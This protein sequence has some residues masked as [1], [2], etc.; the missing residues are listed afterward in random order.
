MTSTY[1][2]ASELL[3]A[4][5]DKVKTNIRAPIDVD[6]IAKF[7]RIEVNYDPS[8]ESMDA[9]GQICFDDGSP[10]IKLNPMQNKY[11]SRRRFTLA[12]ELG[13]FC[14]HRE[15]NTSGFI[16]SQKTMSRT[17]SYWDQYESEANNFAAQLLM[18]KDLIIEEGRL[19]IQEYSDDSISAK[20]FIE[21][22]SEKFQVSNKA[23][24]YRLKNI[25]ILK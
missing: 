13:H 9:I 2:N 25:G 4:F 22:I 16:D 14:L 21:K 24:E 6:S 17:A 18:P 3:K 5:S 10:V 20:L 11:E 19:I 15:A 8:L 1:T 7:L 12:H 23:M